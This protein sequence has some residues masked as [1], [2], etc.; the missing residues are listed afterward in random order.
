MVKL[1]T[2]DI[3]MGKL[4]PPEDVANVVA[5]SIWLMLQEQQSISTAHL[6]YVESELC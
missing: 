6:M 4:V 3:P 5:F 1:L 2:R